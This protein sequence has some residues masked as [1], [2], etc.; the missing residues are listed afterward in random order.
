MPRSGF[1][2]VQTSLATSTQKSGTPARVPP[3]RWYGARILHGSLKYHVGAGCA[4][5]EPRSSRVL[6]VTGSARIGQRLHVGPRVCVHSEGDPLR[7]GKASLTVPFRLQWGPNLSHGVERRLRRVP[8]PIYP[9]ADRSR[10]PTA[11]RP[12]EVA[13]VSCV[14]EHTI[15]VG[16]NLLGYGRKIMAR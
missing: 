12:C 1:P 4:A 7:L 9:P 10:S 13:Q 14:V 5:V 3:P 16:S 8:Q 11:E 15:T 6:V 2:G